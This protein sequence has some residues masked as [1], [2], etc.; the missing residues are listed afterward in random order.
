MKMYVWGGD[1]GWKN[2]I[3]RFLVLWFSG[4]VVV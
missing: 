3:D 4:L 2:S 1:V